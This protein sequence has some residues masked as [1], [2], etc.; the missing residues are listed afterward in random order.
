MPSPSAKALES[1][2]LSGAAKPVLTLTDM[3]SG[4]AVNLK[5]VELAKTILGV[6]IVICTL[7]L[8]LV[9]V[10]HWIWPLP[11]FV[12]WTSLT[13]VALGSVLFLI[14][15]LVPM[16]GKRIN[17][18]FAAREIER[19]VP[20]LKDSLVS[21][22]QLSNDAQ[23]TAPKSVVTAVGK[24]AVDRLSKHDIGEF[25]ASTTPLK[26]AMW[27][28][29]LMV[30]SG[31]YLVVS[32]KSGLDSLRRLF[33]PWQSIEV[34]SRVKF[35][36]VTPKDAVVARGQTL[37]V[38]V[39]LRGLLSGDLVA[40]EFS[41]LDGQYVNQRIELEPII[42]GLTYS[43]KLTMGEAG[44]DQPLSYTIVAGDATAGP[45]R[46][47]VEVVPLVAVEKIELA[48][49]KYTKLPPQVIDEPSGFEA[50]E[51]A[52]IKVFAKANQAMESGRIE[53]HPGAREDDP[54]NVRRLFSMTT[55]Q[56]DL[57]GSF[58]AKLNQQ[59]QDPSLRPIELLP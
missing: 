6:A 49:P 31:V 33:M 43:G 24:F 13:V 23:A 40:I 37:D 29:F 42:E 18:I 35:V 39:E 53:L 34:P 19:K 45:Y 10:D 16:F 22:M 9:L 51:G 1:K 17:P 20:E 58:Q 52:F 7:V 11:A 30:F 36:K 15:R 3:V 21:Y 27:L 46:V 44:I 14:N 50:L 48:F 54:L 8:V 2:P 32:P 5:R 55:R 28:F 4:A 12:R 56:R 47:D 57:S 25:I 38:E 59:R 26:L 41:T